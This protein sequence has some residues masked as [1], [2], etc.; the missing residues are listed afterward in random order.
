M[1]PTRGRS[2]AN[3][4]AGEYP[5]PRNHAIT[6]GLCAIPSNNFIRSKK[7]KFMKSFYNWT[8]VGRAVIIA[9]A[10]FNENLFAA[11]FTDGNIIICRVGDGTTA[12]ASTGDPVFLDEY[13]TS[14][15]LV[16]SIPMP[17]TSSGSGNSPN[18]LVMSGTATSEGLITRSTDGRYIIITGYKSTIP[19]GSSL[20]ASLSTTVPRTVGRVDSSGN[21]DTTTALTDFATGSN[22]RSA[23]SSDGT[24]FWLTSGVTSPRYATFGATTSLQISTTVANE[25]Q[26]N[27][28]N[29]QLYISD[30]SGSAVRIGAVGT[31]LPTTAG[32]TIVNL[33]GFETSGSPYAFFFCTLNGGSSYDTLYV[34]DDTNA[35]VSLQKWALVSGNWVLKNSVNENG[36]RGLVGVVNGTTVTLY[37]T[38]GASAATGGGTFWSIT[39]TAGYNANFSTTTPTVLATATTDQAFRGVALAP[40]LV[41]A[42]ADTIQRPNGSGNGTKI[43]VGTLLNN[44]SVSSGTKSIT[45]VS[46]TSTG[47]GTVTLANGWVYYTPSG[48]PASDTFTYTLSDGLGGTATGTVTVN[49]LPPN[50]AASLNVVYGPMV[51]SGNFIVR[52]AGVPSDTYTVESNNVMSGTGWVKQGNYTAPADNTAGFGIGIFQ[53]SDPTDG[54]SRFYRT[55][56]PSY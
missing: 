5:K 44:D 37:S 25:R 8:T 38:T 13:T 50:N 22:P 54:T 56:Y 42:G 28:F 30:S 10:I 34:A 39:D 53:V 43:D 27:I 3:Q 9:F 26:V 36:V 55:V 51:V 41:T 48:N 32:Q 4:S 16:Q 20:P 24:A 46:P 40:F 29:G 6:H 7:S 21:I 31:G 49:L 1:C 15:T 35:A 12:E 52:F 11:A 14:G 45:A 2:A 17:T 47:G 18:A 23:V 33:P 19:A